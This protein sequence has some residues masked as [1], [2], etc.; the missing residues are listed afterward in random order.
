M[1]MDLT[2]RTLI[3]GSALAATLPLGAAAAAPIE[4]FPIWPGSPPGGEGLS[5]RDE[6]VRRSVNGPADDIAWPHVATPMLNVVPATQPNGGAILYVPGGGYARVAVGREGSGIARAF[7][8]RGFTVFELLYRLPRDGWAAGPDVSLQDA[9]RAMRLIRA[10]AGKWRIDPA[11]VAAMGFS[12][13]GHLTARLA[14]R[15]ALRTYDPVDAAD[16]QSARP[17]VAGLF[18]PVIT[19]ADPVAHAASKR[20]LLGSDASPARIARFSAEND[21]PAD[22]PPTLVAHAADDPVV[23]PGNSLAMFAALQAARIPSELHIFEK[24]G[25]GLPL[26]EA[27]R[28][29]PWPALFER[30]ARNH[31]M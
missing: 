8:A 9:Q 21:L 29:H 3:A 23:S 26:K 22:M 18:F 13:G 5:V 24:G 2:R 7:A 15:A 31:G 20:E 11:R 10:G 14:S 30:F 12:A 4:R 27:G 6:T 25:H 1:D 19:M 16:A 28:D 17:I